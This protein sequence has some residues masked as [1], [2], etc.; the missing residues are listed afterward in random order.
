MVLATVAA[1][2]GV[3]MLVGVVVIRVVQCNRKLSGVWKPF[4][5]VTRPLAGGR[6]RM[7]A[8]LKHVGRKSGRAYE[9]PLGAWPYGDGFVLVLTY[10]PGTDWCRNVLASGVCTLK[11]RG[12]EYILERPEIIPLAEAIDVY[13]LWVRLMLAAID[14]RFLLYLHPQHGTSTVSTLP[15]PL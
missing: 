15:F 7:Y 10:G 6:I 1:L 4:N 12:H 9:T 2:L 11:T 14:V 13:P 5:A 8:L 3:C